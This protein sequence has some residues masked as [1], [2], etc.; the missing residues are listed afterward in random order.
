MGLARR[1]GQLRHGM[2]FRLPRS[3][4]ALVVVNE[5]FG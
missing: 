4:I 1:H 5:A 3:A 2:P